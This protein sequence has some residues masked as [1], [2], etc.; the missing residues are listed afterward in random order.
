[1]LEKDKKGNIFADLVIV[2]MIFNVVALL[3]SSSK[4]GAFEFFIDELST[5]ILILIS[6]SVIDNISSSMMNVRRR[7]A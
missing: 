3:K 4:A 1:M 2:T 7:L 5:K 6:V